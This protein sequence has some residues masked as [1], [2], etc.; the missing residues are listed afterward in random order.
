MNYEQKY[1]EAL[2]KA[3][4][5]YNNEGCRPVD[6]GV[7]FPELRDGEDEWIRKRLIQAL[8]GDVLNIRETY[9]A[10]AWLEKQD[11][12]WK[13]SEEQL[14][15]LKEALEHIPDEYDVPYLTTLLTTLYE[16]LKK[17]RGE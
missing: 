4:E 8:H 7:I 13:P 14:G 6:L 1:K 16:E 5:L 10:I 11:S 9:I 15:A 3:K 17:L 2:E 12:T